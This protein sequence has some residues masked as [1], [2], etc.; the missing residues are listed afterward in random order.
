[1]SRLHLP[2]PHIAARVAAAFE[3]AVLERLPHVTS[4]DDLT[5]SAAV[6]RW[7]EW[8]PTHEWMA[9][10]GRDKGETHA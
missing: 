3:H 10:H 5:T 6:A 8:T 2:H 1:M 4:A 9:E 7:A